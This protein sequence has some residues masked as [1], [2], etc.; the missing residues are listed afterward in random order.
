MISIFF[1]DQQLTRPTI[2]REDRR[3]KD[4]KSVGEDE[5]NKNSEQE[6]RMKDVRKQ[7]S[8]Y[9]ENLGNIKSANIKKKIFVVSD[10]DKIEIQPYIL[11]ID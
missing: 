1:P 4:H 6:Y 3:S 2:E 10:G 7:K 9:Y 8:K 5:I 11:D